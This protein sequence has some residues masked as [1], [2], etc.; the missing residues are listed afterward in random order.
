MGLKQ[1][2]YN[3]DFNY[4]DVVNAD[5]YF[6]IDSAF[7]GQGR[8]LG[9]GEPSYVNGPSPAAIADPGIVIAR[10][11]ARKQDHDS[12]LATLFASQPVR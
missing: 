1:G 8:P 6:L 3:G 7:I 5:D 10:Q 11:P 9:V 12:L 4:D 2:W